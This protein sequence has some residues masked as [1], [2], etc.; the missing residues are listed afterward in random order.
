MKYDFIFIVLVYRNTKD[1]QD[2]FAS[3][4]LPRSKVIVVNSF[5]DEESDK[6]FKLIAE[7]NNA[8]YLS[9]PNKGY[10]AGNNRGIEYAISNYDFKY[11]VVSNAD[12]E[13]GSMSAES[14]E[15]YSS[16]I[17]APDI[18]NL[19]G[20]HQNPH[21]PFA[22]SKLG[23]MLQY[24]VYKYNLPKL[25]IVFAI[26][27][28]LNKSLFYLLNKFCGYN[29]VFAAHGAFF[30]LPKNVLLK[31]VPLYDENVFMYGEETHVGML[32][33]KNGITTRYL[34]SIKIR[35]KEDGSSSLANLNMFKLEKQSFEALLK[36]WYNI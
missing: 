26:L 32:A 16:D 14:L 35:H 33:A 7:G 22:K 15:N 21:M 17:I 19:K 20:R 6:N 18:V 25:R 27:S 34:P 3:L 5:Y 29:K 9:V 36:Y 1:L 23:Y 30:V 2:F 31:L 10:G 8:D 13:I 4:M 11:L 28:R 24:S 12:I